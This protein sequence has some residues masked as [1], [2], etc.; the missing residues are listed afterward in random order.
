MKRHVDFDQLQDYREGLLS[1]DEHEMISVHL[2]ECPTCSE[3]L[4]GLSDLMNGLA[5]LP[6]E[7]TPARDLWPQIE[8]RIGGS[9][10]AQEGQPPRRSV[11]MPLWQLLAA[12][13]TVALVSGGA[14]WTF[15]AGSPQSSAP[16]LTGPATMAQPAGLQ[17]G[18]ED[19]ERAAL[20]LEG[21][22]AEAQGILDPETIRVLEANLMLI[23][24]AIAESLGA[25]SEDPGSRTLRRILSETMRRKMDLLQ[26]VATVIY[27]NT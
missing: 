19:Y 26:Q 16:F 18:Y 5:E 22:L 7:A 10:V 9:E 4:V 3:N 12:S 17:T 21:I 25:L 27:A 14:V 24:E 20:E 15:L 13:I 2:G 11:T 1:P 6:E 8:W 23:D